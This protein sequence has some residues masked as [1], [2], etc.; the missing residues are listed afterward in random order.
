MEVF[1]LKWLN[2]FKKIL[3]VKE[4]KVYDLEDMDLDQREDY[5]D[6]LN[7]SKNLQ[8][9]IECI[10]KLFGNSFDLGIREIKIGEK[11]IDVALVFIAGMSD[12]NMIQNIIKD[13][14]INLMEASAPDDNKI[15]EKVV[16]HVLN[17]KEI[18]VLEDFSEVLKNITIGSTV[19]FINGYKRAISCETMGM[20]TRS[21]QEPEAEIAIRGPRDGFVENIYTNTSMLRQRIRGAHLWLQS[22][23]IGYLSRTK[24]AMAYIKGLASEELIEEVKSRIENIDIDAV[25][26]SGYIE[27][28]ILDENYTLFPLIRRTE[29]PDK[30]VSCL[31]EGKVAI[32]TEGT[33]FV[34]ILPTSFMSLLQAP[35]DYYEMFPLGSFIRVLRYFGFIMSVILPGTY[36]AVVNFHSELIPIELLL[37]IAAT[38]EGVPFPLIIEAILMEVLFEVLREAGVRLPRAVGSAISIV[39]ALILGEAAVNAG[40]VSPPMVVIVALTAIASFT[41]PDFSLGLAARLIRFIFLLLGSTVGL[42]GIQFGILVLLIHLCSLRSFGQPYFQPF[43]PLI[44]QDIKDSFLRSPLWNLTNR[45]KLM[46]GRNPQ[47]QKKGQQ[48]H[49]PEEDGDQKK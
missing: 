27:E 12:S 9:N 7:I 14:E 26:E 17:N 46:G 39:G 28:Y 23:E 21:I 44:W 4:K 29:R 5:I 49:P 34:L 6:N 15:F 8:E 10:Q 25:Q 38:R 20:E 11:E 3:P 42:F 32:L 22:Y 36:V 30:V 40:L 41:V 18:M 16:N 31:L 35:D 19:I 24:V 33:P 1:L 47:R 37:R 45:P 48:P 2:F 43:G 13:L